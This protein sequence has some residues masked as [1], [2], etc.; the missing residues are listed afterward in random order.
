MY[1]YALCFSILDIFI[2]YIYLYFLFSDHVKLH[3]PE[4]IHHD[5]HTKVITIHHHHHKPKKEHHHHHHH[6]HQPKPHKPH[7]HHYH[8]HKTST[9][10]VSKGHSSHHGHGG[11]SGHHGH[12]KHHG[13]N[14]HGHH[15]HHGHEHKHH[16]SSSI[17]YDPPSI[18]YDQPITSYEPPKFNYNAGPSYPSDYGSFVPSV[19]NIP[20]SPHL[21]GVVHTVKQ[22]KIFDSLPGAI[23]GT[24]SGIGKPPSHG[25]EVKEE[26]EEG[27]D[28]VYTAVNSLSQTYPSTYGYVRN[29]APSSGNDPF[30]TIQQSTAQVPS[31]DPFA[32][33]E[34]PTS[35]GNIGGVTGS[36]VAF[37]TSIPTHSAALPSVQP[38]Q[39]V[40]NDI[41]GATGFDDPDNIIIGDVSSTAYLS[42]EGEGFNDDSPTSFSREAGIQQTIK[43]GGV[44]SFVY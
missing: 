38:S 28:D 7:G 32:E 11:H 10:S 40:G 35:Y 25:Y 14:S 22:V 31:H 1:F 2:Y 39:F 20:S 27:D 34:Q 29:A 36:A 5:R 21:H 16:D 43:T 37:A 3:I 42:P 9:H 13:H 33:I 30:S 24:Q 41:S 6:H 15:G 26:E 19:P 12:H 8:H 18:S 17:S 23:P 44:E 4:F